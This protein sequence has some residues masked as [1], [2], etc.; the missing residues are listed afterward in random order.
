MKPGYYWAKLVLYDWPMEVV[1][2]ER[3][4][5]WRHGSDE[6]YGLEHFAFLGP[7]K[8]PSIRVARIQARRTRPERFPTLNWSVLCPPGIISAQP[9][10]WEWVVQASTYDDAR[11]EFRKTFDLK[12]IPHGVTFTRI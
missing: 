1:R 3:T 2:I 11:A 12:R 10:P 5:V 6:P 9:A 8:P 7:C 4:S